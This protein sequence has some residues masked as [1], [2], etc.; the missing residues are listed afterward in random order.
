MGVIVGEQAADDVLAPK[1]TAEAP[2]EAG[3]LVQIGFISILE[4]E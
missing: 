2:P 1:G 3:I 4:G